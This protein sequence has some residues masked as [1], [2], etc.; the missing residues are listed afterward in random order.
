MNLLLGGFFVS[1]KMENYKDIQEY[2][3]LYEVSNIGSIRNK[4]N[5]HILNQHPNRKGYPH[6]CMWVNKKVVTKSVHRLVLNAFNPHEDKTLHV[7]HINGIK[8][9]NRIENLEWVSNRE[10]QTHKFLN[11]PQTSRFN[12]VCWSVNH[13]QYLAQI[14]FNGKNHYLGLHRTEEA[15]YARVIK[16]H[17]ENGI[18]NKYG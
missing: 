18:V 12:G 3:D 11:K 15:A 14:R 6:V 9:D 17:E 1:L 7:N 16:F 2:E 8:T 5:R 4:L 10:N 13:G